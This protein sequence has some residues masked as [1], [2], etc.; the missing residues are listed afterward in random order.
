MLFIC[1]LEA[2]KVEK[3]LETQISNDV[4][5]TLICVFINIYKGYIKKTQIDRSACAASICVFGLLLQEMA[6]KSQITGSAL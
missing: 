2:N 6:K 3:S 1:D 4:Y 5:A